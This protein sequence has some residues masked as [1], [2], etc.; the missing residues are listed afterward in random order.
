MP[1]ADK[2]KAR[3][4]AAAA[5]G[6]LHSFLAK[7]DA[8]VVREMDG[9]RG[10]GYLHALL[11]FLAA[12]DGVDSVACAPGRLFSS[13][14]FSSPLLAIR[15]ARKRKV[16][17]TLL[18]P[19]RKSP[20][21][22]Q[23]THGKDGHVVGDSLTIADLSVFVMSSLIG[24]GFYDGIDDAVLIDFKNIQS[25]RKTVASHEEVGKH[26]SDKEMWG[27]KWGEIVEKKFL[28]AKDL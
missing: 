25:V 28:S 27:E 14:L 18:A 4:E 22:P 26:Y 15:F 12:L 9:C 8:F 10:E 2:L 20:L 16:T 3:A 23:G 11:R 6:S 21:P 17:E 13:P 19:L 24:C 5:G 7:L 1:A